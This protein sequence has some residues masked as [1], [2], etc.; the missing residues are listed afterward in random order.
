MFGMMWKEF[1]IIIQNLFASGLHQNDLFT[2]FQK[3]TWGHPRHF[4]KSGIKYGLG[5][6]PTIKGQANKGN[7]SIS[8]ILHFLFEGFYPIVIDKLIK[9]FIK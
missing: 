4:L 7:M 3:F 8:R 6:K 9:V 2:L 1:L 5:I